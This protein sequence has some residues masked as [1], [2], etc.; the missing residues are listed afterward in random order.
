M[1]ERVAAL[2][3]YDRGRSC[4]EQLDRLKDTNG[5]KDDFDVVRLGNKASGRL[6]DS[7]PPRMTD[8]NVG[9][10]SFTGPTVRNEQHTRRGLSGPTTSANA[11][12][13]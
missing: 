4:D 1:T 5:V 7:I 8:A 3:E 2:L 9:N 11:A 6:H 13:I 10:E 12:A